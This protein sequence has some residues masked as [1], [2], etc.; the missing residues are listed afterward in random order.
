M[1]RQSPSGGTGGDSSHDAQVSQYDESANGGHS[2][3][4]TKDVASSPSPSSATTSATTSAAGKH[5]E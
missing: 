1:K 5:P 3:S 2:I 4:K